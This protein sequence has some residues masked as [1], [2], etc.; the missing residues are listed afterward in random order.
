MTVDRDKQERSRST[1]QLQNIKLIKKKKSVFTFFW[2][3]YKITK[4][5]LSLTTFPPT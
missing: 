1:Y 5:P 3:G 2:G 4:Y